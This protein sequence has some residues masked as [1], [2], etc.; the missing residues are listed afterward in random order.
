MERDRRK[1]GRTGEGA[2]ARRKAS[3]SCEISLRA[4]FLVFRLSLPRFVAQRRGGWR[5][6]IYVAHL[7]AVNQWRP[8]LVFGLL[9]AATVRYSLARVVKPRPRQSGESKS[10]ARCGLPANNASGRQLESGP[11]RLKAGYSVVIVPL[12]FPLG[13]RIYSGSAPRLVTLLQPAARSRPDFSPR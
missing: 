13:R 2:R 6:E 1:E 3:Q 11:R 10:V 4:P 12:R 8:P 7:R 5:G 9:P